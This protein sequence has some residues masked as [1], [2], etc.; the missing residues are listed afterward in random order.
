MAQPAV[1]AVPSA[2]QLLIQQQ[3][4]AENTPDKAQLDWA[5]AADTFVAAS[6]SGGEEPVCTLAGNE[7]PYPG[8][9]ISQKVKVWNVANA[10]ATAFERMLQ[11]AGLSSGICTVHM[12]PCPFEFK[13][14]QV[15]RLWA[16]LLSG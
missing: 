11:E 12:S 6:R 7:L 4:D 15:I 1:H 3:L 5:E 13:K 8:S 9:E 14:V 2:V 16:T 10:G